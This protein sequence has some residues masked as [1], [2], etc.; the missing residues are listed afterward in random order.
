MMGHIT[1]YL[2][3]YNIHPSQNSLIAAEINLISIKDE[4]KVNSGPVYSP[5]L[6]TFY[7]IS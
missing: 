1:H 6:L 5:G 3:I 2:S 7:F 4:F